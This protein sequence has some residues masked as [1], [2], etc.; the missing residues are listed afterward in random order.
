MHVEHRVASRNIFLHFI[1]A[2]YK[3]MRSELNQPWLNQNLHVKLVLEI[4]I[5]TDVG[6]L[7]EIAQFSHKGRS[8]HFH[9][10]THFPH[11]FWPMY[12]QLPSTD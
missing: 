2:M 5:P 6:H 9:Y 11:P 3:G 7:L 1:V 4:V 12:R 10:M 8:A